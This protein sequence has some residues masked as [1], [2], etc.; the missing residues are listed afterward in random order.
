[1]TYR[2]T[3]YKPVSLFLLIFTAITTVLVYL[4]VLSGSYPWLIACMI[5]NGFFNLG[6]YSVA[7]EMGVEL[8]FPVGEATS[9]G[10]INSLA[11]IIGFFMVLAVTPI[12]GRQ[13]DSDVWITFLGFEVIL[14]VGALVMGCVK[15][16]LKRSKFENRV[17]RESMSKNNTKIEAVEKIKEEETPKHQT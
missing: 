4:A 1:M 11:N 10:V 13:S 9:N 6:T 16:K 7:Y 17:K 15:V 2:T 12:L 14:I 8:T 3:H 5:L